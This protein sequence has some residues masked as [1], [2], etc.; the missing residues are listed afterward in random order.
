MRFPSRPAL[1]AL[2]GP[3]QR[4]TAAQGDG[5]TARA[6]NIRTGEVCTARVLLPD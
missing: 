3:T 1:V 5:C 2:V 6:R 4:R